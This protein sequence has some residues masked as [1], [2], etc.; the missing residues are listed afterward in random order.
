VLLLREKHP[1]PSRPGIQTSGFH[2]RYHPDRLSGSWNG[3]PAPDRECCR[4]EARNAIRE[5]ITATKI[6]KEPPVYAF[7]PEGVLDFSK[8]LFSHDILFFSL[9]H[10]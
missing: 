2:I 9:R 3:A 8:V 10:H 7:L 4:I 6:V 5:E 1:L